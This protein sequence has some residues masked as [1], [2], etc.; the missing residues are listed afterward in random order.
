MRS[1]HRKLVAVFPV[2]MFI[3]N[4]ALRVLFGLTRVHFARL[5]C[6]AELDREVIPPAVTRS[7]AGAG[8]VPTVAGVPDIVET[9]GGMEP[10]EDGEGSEDVRDECPVLISEQTDLHGVHITLK[11]HL[12]HLSHPQGCKQIH[13]KLITNCWQ[14]PLN[15]GQNV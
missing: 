2:C 9:G 13:V 10:E 7:V 14:S 5:G 12:K 1:G 4:H 8:C 15:C 6:C 11:V 3:G